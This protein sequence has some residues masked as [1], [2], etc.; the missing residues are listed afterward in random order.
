[1]FCLQYTLKYRHTRTI[2]HPLFVLSHFFFLP[3]RLVISLTFLRF[4]LHKC[5]K[6]PYHILILGLNLSLDTRPSFRYR[7]DCLIQTDRIRRDGRVSSL[8][9]YWTR[10]LVTDMSSFNIDNNIFKKIGLGPFTEFRPWAL[11]RDR[12][13]YWVLYT[14]WIVDL[15]NLKLMSCTNIWLSFE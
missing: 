12:Y 3:L 10:L 5:G 9:N 1:M 2:S 4:S 11:S 14:D 13:D 8:T 15:S 7:S 6:T